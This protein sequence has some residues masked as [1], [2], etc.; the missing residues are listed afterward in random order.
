MCRRRSKGVEVVDCVRGISGVVG[1][2]GGRERREND[3]F[4]YNIGGVCKV[5]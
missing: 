4:L 3:C 5:W 2:L 1:H